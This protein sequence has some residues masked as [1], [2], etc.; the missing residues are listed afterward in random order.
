MDGSK[1]DVRYKLEELG[2]SSKPFAN[3]VTPEKEKEG[4]EDCKPIANSDCKQC[5]GKCHSGMC[6]PTYFNF[7]L[8]FY[9]LFDASTINITGGFA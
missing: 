3:H 7:I 2:D 5:S 6:K 9:S 1:L 8:V 4:M